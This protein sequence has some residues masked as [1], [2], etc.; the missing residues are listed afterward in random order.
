M[1]DLKDRK[2]D[3]LKFHYYLFTLHRSFQQQGPSQTSKKGLQTRKKRVCA[4][5]AKLTAMLHLVSPER[6]SIIF[7]YI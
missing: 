6:K 1:S 7:T 5:V 4:F 3:I 2:T